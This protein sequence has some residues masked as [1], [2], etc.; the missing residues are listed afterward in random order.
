MFP[1][2]PREEETVHENSLS[3][4]YIAYLADMDSNLISGMSF[5]RNVNM[6]LIHQ[7]DGEVAAVQT[8]SLNLTSYPTNS[9][10]KGSS[11]LEQNYDL[12][13]V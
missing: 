4:E 3:K 5:T 1:E 10:A 12:L 7:N 8:D 9:E 6:N 2:Q 13:K 11:F